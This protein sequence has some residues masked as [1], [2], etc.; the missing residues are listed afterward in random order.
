LELRTLRG[1][2]TVLPFFSERTKASLTKLF[3]IF[4]D[5][6]ATGRDGE[7]DCS[8]SLMTSWQQGEM[9]RVTVLHL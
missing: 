6:L 1:Y 3:F 7:S 2:N 8:S 9:E 5:K 4:D